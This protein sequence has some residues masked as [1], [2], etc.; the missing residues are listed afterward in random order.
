MPE[1][2]TYLYGWAEIYNL[3]NSS[4]LREGLDISY[5]EEKN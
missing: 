3:D 1:S 5:K 4:S 2:V